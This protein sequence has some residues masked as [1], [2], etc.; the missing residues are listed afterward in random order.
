MEE[1]PPLGLAEISEQQQQNENYA[2]LVYVK[3]ALVARLI[4]TTLQAED[5][6]LDEAMRAIFNSEQR[7]LSNAD[8]QQIFHDVYSGLVDDLFERYVISGANL[9]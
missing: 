4:D 1:D 8:L 7:G 6:S 2:A 5:R 3:G 9:P